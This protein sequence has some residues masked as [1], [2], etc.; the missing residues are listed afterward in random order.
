MTPKE[1]ADHKA[2]SKRLVSVVAFKS[3]KRGKYPKP[4]HK[5]G[6]PRMQSTDLIEVSDTHRVVFI[7]RDGE[8]R[9]DSAF[10]GYLFCILGT[11]ELSP[12]FEMHFHPS[13]KGL[14]VKLPCKT[15]SDYTSR[16][17]P[18]A[19][20]LALSVRHDIDPRLEKDRDVLIDRFCGSCGIAMGS[21]GGILN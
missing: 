14:H 13:H 20:E 2:V 12:L 3:L 1:L 8:L 10:F 5:V 16:M 9:T 17:L 18:G 4:L 11:G 6:G 19:P 21:V 15:E 7:W